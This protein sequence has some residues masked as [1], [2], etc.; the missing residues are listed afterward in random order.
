M[1]GFPVDLKGDRWTTLVRLDAE[2][3]DSAVRFLERHGEATVSEKIV[4]ERAL[5]AL[6][7]SSQLPA[8]VME[9]LKRTFEAHCA[10]IRPISFPLAGKALFENAR[11]MESYARERKLSLGQAALAYECALLGMTQDDAIQEMGRR[12]AIMKDACER[13]LSGKFAFSM[14]L[15]RPFAHVNQ[16][17]KSVV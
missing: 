7:R 5:I 3:L 8:E 15:L 12:Y 14:Q 6:N 16:D 9:A 2:R 1:D 17:R 11:E 10:T 13:S 4:S